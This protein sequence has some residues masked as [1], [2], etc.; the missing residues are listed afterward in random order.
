MVT[1]HP[2]EKSPI[3]ND[4][5]ILPEKSVIIEHGEINM[6]NL[7]KVLIAENS[8]LETP[9]SEL[10]QFSDIQSETQNS[11]LFVQVDVPYESSF[12]SEV[13]KILPLATMHVRVETDATTIQS[14][15]LVVTT[16]ES[17]NLKSSSKED[18]IF[19]DEHDIQKDF[20]EEP[21]RDFESSSSGIPFADTTQIKKETKVCLCNPTDLQSTP[22]SSQS[23]ERFEVYL[24]LLTSFFVLT[25]AGK[26]YT[27][28][29]H[30]QQI[31]EAYP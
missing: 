8:K 29:L 23:V 3:P 30:E 6:P 1:S 24:Y 20:R 26:S 15:N 21:I 27:R 10:G 5:P 14:E 9:V 19:I 2:I 22:Q 12:S 28:R 18:K 25:V 16:M 17:T 13:H 7:S 11:L 4:I 31:A